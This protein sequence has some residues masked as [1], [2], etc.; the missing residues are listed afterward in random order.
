MNNSTHKSVHLL[1]EGEIHSELH[2]DPYAHNCFILNQC[3]FYLK[4]VQNNENQLQPG[5][6]CFSDNET[7][8]VCLTPSQ[9]ITAFITRFLEQRQHT[10]NSTIDKANLK[11]L[12]DLEYLQVDSED[13]KNLENSENS[14]DSEDSGSLEGTFWSSF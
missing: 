5:F 4:V 6:V 13:L 7:S 14:D 9:A 3:Q 1:A 12:Y 10:Q 8:K 11:L 2:Y